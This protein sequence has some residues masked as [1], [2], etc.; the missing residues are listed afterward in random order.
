MKRIYGK[1]VK[2]R[3]H[4]DYLLS[5]PVYRYIRPCQHLILYREPVPWGEWAWCATCKTPFQHDENTREIAPRDKRKRLSDARLSIMVDEACVRNRV[6][7]LLWQTG[8]EEVSR[9]LAADIAKAI[10]C[11]SRTVYRVAEDLG[12]GI[13]LE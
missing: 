13:S 1:P 11:V 10:G 4:K 9:E 7:D 5:V 8:M 3:H 2:P 12:I 6:A